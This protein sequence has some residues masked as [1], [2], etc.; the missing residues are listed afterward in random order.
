MKLVMQRALLG[1]HMLLQ[2]QTDVVDRPITIQLGDCEWVTLIEGVSSNG[3][4][5]PPML[6]FVGKVHIFTWYKNV[7][8]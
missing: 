5:L 1:Q 6:I 7:T 4:L 3:W 8:E 2:G